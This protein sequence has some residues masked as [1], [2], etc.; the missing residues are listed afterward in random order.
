VDYDI[1]PSGRLIEAD[2]EFSLI[3]TITNTKRLPVEFLRTGELVPDNITLPGGKVELSQ[4]QRGSELLSDTYLMPRQKLTRTRKVTLPKRGQYYFRGATLTAGSFLGLSEIKKDFHLVREVVVPPKPVKTS[5]LKDLLGRYIGDISVYMF[6]LEDPI[7]TIG[8]RDY[9]EHD[10]MRA[11]CWKQT[12]RLGKLM[13]K[14]FDHTLDL[15][16]T[17]ILNLDS[18]KTN[19][20]ETVF[21]MAR[22]VCEFL[23][24]MEI[25]YRFVT[26]ASVARSMGRSVIPD[27]FGG[28][29]LGTI[30]ELLGRMTYTSFEGL[31][32]TLAK[33]VKGAE[34]GRSHILL[35][36]EDTDSVSMFLHK[37]RVRTGRDVLVLTPESLNDETEMRFVV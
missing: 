37:L 14:N 16:A 21:S 18:R 19:G 20:H 26:N 31:A 25:S 6:L 17:V 3:T 4:G 27:G 1:K 30:L 13:V 15:T 2:E 23:E 5:D 7:L 8:F 35:T 28:D 29:H 32:N 9:T 34:P 33:I 10:P 24:A 36:P 11:I 12:A 22:S